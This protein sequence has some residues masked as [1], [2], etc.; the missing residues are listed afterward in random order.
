ML[1]LENLL[2]RGIA[3]GPAAFRRLCVETLIDAIIVKG[4]K[5]AAFR[6][7]CVETISRS[8]FFCA[9][10]PAAFRRLCVETCFSLRPTLRPSPAAFRRLCVETLSVPYKL[11]NVRASRLQ[12]AVC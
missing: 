8:L 3:L 7:L 4:D 6:R 11:S 5:P 2:N 1:K 9:I 12:A 10:R